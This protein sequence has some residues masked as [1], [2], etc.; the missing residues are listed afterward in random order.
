L[1]FD[2]AFGRLLRALP[3]AD[4]GPSDK[5]T[6]ANLQKLAGAMVGPDDEPKDGADPE[7]SGIPALYTY[8]GQFV[9]HDLTFDP[10]SSLQQQNDVDGL[11][12]YRTPRFDLDNVYGRGAD[13]QPYLYQGGPGT[14]KFILGSPLTG[15]TPAT[16]AAND[17]PR[18]AGAPPRAIIGDPRNDENVIVSQ[19]QGLFLRFHNRFATEHASLS[20]ADVQQE[21]RFHYQWLLIHDF[22]PRLI[23]NSVLHEVF[24]HLKSGQSWADAPPVLRLYKAKN[25][26]FM[27][28]EFSAA[29]YRF[30]HSMVRPGYRL[31]NGDKTLLPIFGANDP[32]LGRPAS[33]RGFMPPD[34]S[35]GID[36][37]RFIDIEERANGVMLDDSGN[38]VGTGKPPTEAQKAEMKRR[39]QLAY[40]I[41]TSIVKPLSTLP[42]DVAD[43]IVRSLALRN[44]ERGWRLRLPSGQAVARALGIPPLSVVPIGSFEDGVKVGT[45]STKP[46]FDLNKT[47]GFEAFRD[48]CPL[49][50]YCLAETF[51]SAAPGKF[52]VKSKVLGPVGGRIVAEIFAGLLVYDS[53]SLVNVNPRW[54]PAIAGAHFGLK[55]FVRYALGQEV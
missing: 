12:D 53:H 42:V 30:G 33:L 52:N 28:L 55:E 19:L 18:N 21:V 13:D 4:F 47:P 20:F 6:L 5:D 36:W 25:E 17:L 38:V 9:D 15:G 7:E 29:A 23:D 2:G 32:D 35:W 49:W 51:S 43:Q 3:P 40:R 34:A 46:P 41:D 16:P 37:A 31:N 11:V 14:P 50:T 39:L 54:T 1:L 26:P 48:N 24:P 8:L 27:P 45:D 44:L 22:L 10:A